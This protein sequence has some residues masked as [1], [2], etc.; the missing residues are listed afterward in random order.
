MTDNSA[1]ASRWKIAT[2]GFGTIANDVFTGLKTIEGHA[3]DWAVL[4]RP[5]SPRRAHV[6]ASAIV[7][8]SLNELLDWQPDLVIEAAG[9]AAV[10]DYVPRILRSGVNVVLV[11]IGALADAAT[12]DIVVDAARK[13]HARLVLPAGAIASLDYLGALGNRTGT[14]VLYESRKPVAAWRQELCVLG[15]DPDDINEEVELFKGTASA[16]ALRYP[17]NLNV[18]ATLGL[19]GVGMEGTQVRVVADPHATGNQHRIVVESELGTLETKLVNSPSPNNPKTSWIVA[20]SVV[21]AVKRQFAPV[22]IGG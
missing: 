21:H 6:P 11:S 10:Q 14:T 5:D 12:Y 7:F 18:A 22:L 9:Q 13:G 2:I 17:K 15:L 16:A 4:L 20:Q 1:A 3:T 19:A 8:S